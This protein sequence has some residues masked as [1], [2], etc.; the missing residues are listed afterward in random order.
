M[1]TILDAGALQFSHIQAGVSA[2][3][4]RLYETIAHK[5]RIPTINLTLQTGNAG[6]PIGG[7][8]CHA[9]VNYIGLFYT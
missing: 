7:D 4:G 2:K 9:A 8:I 6:Q 3:Q 5:N 1:E